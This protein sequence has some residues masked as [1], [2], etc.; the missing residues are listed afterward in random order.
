MTFPGFNTID[1][2]GKKCTQL[3]FL[4]KLLRRVTFETSIKEGQS[5]CK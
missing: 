2:Q 3:I 4:N 5:F 1:R